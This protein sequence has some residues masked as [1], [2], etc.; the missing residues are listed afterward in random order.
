[1]K[2]LHAEILKVAG[3]RSVWVAA[4]AGALAAPALAALNARALAARGELFSLGQMQEALIAVAAVAFIAA[5]IMGQEWQPMPAEAGGG[6]QSLA[7]RSATPRA[8]SWL[9]AK[10]VVILALSAAVMAAALGGV[11][12]ASGAIHPAVLAGVDARTLA[13]IFVYGLLT[14]QFCAGLTLLLRGGLIPTVW[15][16]A[17]STVISVGYL[18]AIHF[19][20]AWFLPDAIG[21]AIIRFTPEPGMPSPAVATAA[22]VGWVLLVWVAGLV[23][24]WRG[25]E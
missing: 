22:Y 24:E 17:N 15:M 20:P 4:L 14:A 7:T 10:F 19:A 5:T 9:A 16:V 25:D 11:V 2:H 6:R 1:M 12:A 23:R 3:L 13:S 21:T 18:V 8:S